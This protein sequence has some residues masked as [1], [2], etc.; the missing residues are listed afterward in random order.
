MKR[1]PEKA[2]LYSLWLMPHGRL[3]EKLQK[4]IADLSMKHATPC[5]P[6]HVTLIGSINIT[7]T[8]AVAKTTTLGR[9]IAPFA[10]KVSDMAYLD[11]YFR[12]LFIKAHKTEDLM[13]ANAAARYLFVLQSTEEYMPH[14]SLVYGHLTTQTK[15]DIVENI[16]KKIE[17]EFPVEEIYLYYTGGQP[18]AWRCISSTP[19]G[20]QNS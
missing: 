18:K 1:D 16:G 17:F 3:A 9:K 2:E 12:C 7:R 4:L 20:Y 14:L 6:P 11:E 10:V 19:C 13:S 15:L 8:E 5:F